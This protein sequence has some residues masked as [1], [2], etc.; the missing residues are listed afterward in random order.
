MPLASPFE[1]EQVASSSNAQPSLKPLRFTFS[2]LSF[3]D[4]Q[5][6]SLVGSWFFFLPSS[7]PCAAPNTTYV[8]SS[9]RVDELLATELLSDQKEVAALSLPATSQ[10][11][12]RRNP[13]SG[14]QP[15]P[16][17][18]LPSLIFRFRFFFLSSVLSGVSRNQF[19]DYVVTFLS[20]FS[21]TG[22]FL[23]YFPTVCFSVFHFSFLHSPKAFR[24]DFPIV[25]T[26]HIL[27]SREHKKEK[28]RGWLKGKKERENGKHE[29]KAKE[30]KISSPSPI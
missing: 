30:R 2:A 29:G 3:D 24:C 16:S 27:H 14:S 12:S 7:K 23:P 6:Y 28:K 25:S 19:S 10:H 26:Q 15:V 20:C 17:F 5:L 9:Q 1:V 4:S 13:L 8:S 21:R 22:P 11:L 18:Y